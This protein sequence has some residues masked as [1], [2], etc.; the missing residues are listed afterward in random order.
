MLHCNALKYT[1]LHCT[2][3]CSA[4]CTVLNKRIIEPQNFRFW[5]IWKTWNY[6]K[7]SLNIGLSIQNL[8][9]QQQKNTAPSANA[10]L[11][12]F[13]G[14]QRIWRVACK[15]TNLQRVYICSIA[16]KS[17][18]KGLALFYLLT[19]QY[20]KCLHWFTCLQTNY[21]DFTFIN[22]LWSW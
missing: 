7:F 12:G 13:Q 15:P 9:L 14:L 22:Y 21:Q 5:F 4:V 6:L 18:C 3:L 1:I 16:N 8:Y 20:S 19:V 11:Q 10:D 17:T 2:T